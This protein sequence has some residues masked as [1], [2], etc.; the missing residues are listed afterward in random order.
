[1]RAYQGGVPTSVEHALLLTGSQRAEC[2][3]WTWRTGVQRLSSPIVTLLLRPI[4][5]WAAG[6][7]TPI[8]V[9]KEIQ[10][11]IVQSFFDPYALALPLF[12]RTSQ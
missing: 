7:K 1:M 10:I 11:T 12:F 4:L 2:R 8:N 3:R 9:T 5:P 6:D